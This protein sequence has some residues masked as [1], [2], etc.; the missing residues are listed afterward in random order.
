MIFSAEVPYGYGHAFG[1]DAAQLWVDIL[2]P[3][4]WDPATAQRIYDAL[5]RA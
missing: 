5:L 3:P 1:P 2:D 4:D